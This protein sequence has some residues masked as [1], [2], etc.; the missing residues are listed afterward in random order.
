MKLRHVGI[1]VTDVEESLK[2]YRDILGF[3]VARIMDESGEHIDNFSALKGVHVK[4]V[5]LKDETNGMIEL[6][7]YHSHPRTA[8]ENDITHIGCSHF[9][10]TVRNLDSIL[11]SIRENGYAINSVPQYSPDGKV[12]LTFCKDPDGALIELVEEIE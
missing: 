8:E 5:K 11:D 7:Q 1:T 4:T 6:L 12:K 10:L 9:A 3:K 2:F